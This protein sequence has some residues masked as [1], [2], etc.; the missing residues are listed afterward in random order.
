[1]LT[2]ES[3]NEALKNVKDPE[4]DMDIITLGLVYGVEVNTPK[5]KVNMTLTTPYCPYG[6]ALINDVK[7][8]VAQLPEVG[9]PSNVDVELV[10]QPPWEPS[11]ELK[12]Q[13][14]LI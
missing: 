1:M 3:I 6:P 5:V 13:M 4:L 10:W 12:V 7:M 8:K 14:G 9:N 11:E 2:K